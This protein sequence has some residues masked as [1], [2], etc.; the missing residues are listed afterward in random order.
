M[1]WNEK[2]GGGLPKGGPLVKKMGEIFFDPP[3]PEVCVRACPMTILR[4]FK[5]R[6]SIE[7]ANYFL[8]IRNNEGKTHPVITVHYLKPFNTP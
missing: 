7:L 4:H 8:L 2:F 3:Q 1:V 6:K 5:V